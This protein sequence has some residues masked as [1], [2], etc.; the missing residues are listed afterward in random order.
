MGNRS[1]AYSARSL[2]RQKLQR[3]THKVEVL[4]GED[5]DGRRD[6][7]AW[8]RRHTAMIAWANE[9]CGPDRYTTASRSV[10]MGGEFRDYIAWH[11]EEAKHAEWFRCA[12]LDKWRG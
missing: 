1:S 9:R 7:N 10:E 6:A 12:F 3:M 8:M 11:F 4:S 2:L 5:A